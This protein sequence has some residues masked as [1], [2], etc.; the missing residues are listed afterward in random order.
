MGHHNR[1]FAGDR[2]A[3]HGAWSPP[4]SSANFCEEDYA[5]TRYFAE[6]INTLT[7]LLYVFFAL[8]Y[9]YGPGSRGLFAPKADFMSVSLFVL[10]IASFLFHASLRHT[11]QFGDELAMIGI[12]W[13][14]L[15]GLLTVRRSSGY[16]RFINTSLAVV[17]PLFAA[18]YLWTGKIIYHVIGFSIAIALIIVRGV[19][20]FYW[21]EPGFPP[22]KVAQW[23]VRGRASLIFMGVAYALWHADL[24]LCAELRNLRQQV[25][26]PWAWLLELHGWWHVLTAMSAAGIMDL[27]REIQEELKREKEE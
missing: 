13:S 16:D 18:F 10:G 17:F 14:I 5:V 22:A 19:Y 15:Q 2:H 23:R 1:H 21:R 8:Q 25:G 3:L 27:V 11:L 7:N 24:E 9:M 12:V 6:F 20:L 26:A 4:T